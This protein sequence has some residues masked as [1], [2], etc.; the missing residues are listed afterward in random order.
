MGSGYGDGGGVR[1]ARDKKTG[2]TSDFEAVFE[3]SGTGTIRSN[4]ASLGGAGVY[5][6][7]KAYLHMK[8][9]AEVNKNNLVYMFSGSRIDITGKLEAA[10]AANIDGAF[11]APTTLLYGDVSSNNNYQKFL[12]KGTTGKFNSSGEL[13]PP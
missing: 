11:T 2:V 4:T 5:L 8:F 10:T 3:M 13:T 7:T 12:Y 6:G 1:L 9:Y